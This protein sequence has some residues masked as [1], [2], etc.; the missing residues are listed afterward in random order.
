MKNSV[1]IVDGIVM[2]RIGNEA[3]VN[4]PGSSTALR[5]SAEA[6]L[7]I[8]QVNAGCT[9]DLG[10][11]VVAQLIT[12]GVLRTHTLLTR[13]GVVRAGAI[14]VGAGV[15]SLAMPSV[16]MASSGAGGD[17]VSIDLVVDGGESPPATAPYLVTVKAQM[18]EGFVNPGGTPVAVSAR[19]GSDDVAISDITYRSLVGAETTW[20]VDTVEPW[21]TSPTDFELVFSWGSTTYR[22]ATTFLGFG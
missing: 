8:D 13:R 15:V 5:V 20:T 22:A 18:P 14:G 19:V 6:L 12:A 9:V 3:L 7:V 21:T 2:E 11:P 4:V 17:E 10:D 1:T 16:A